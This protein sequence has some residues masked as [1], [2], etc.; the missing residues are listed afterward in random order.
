M[1]KVP[2][3]VTV[4]GPVCL[5]IDFST[6]SFLYSALQRK[7]K[8]F[9]G[10]LTVG[11]FPGSCARSTG[12][13]LW[14]GLAKEGTDGRLMVGGRKEEATSFLPVAE[15]SKSRCFSSVSSRLCSDLCW[16]QFILCGP[17]LR[18]QWQHVSHVPSNLDL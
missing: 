11:C 18:L 4:H 15:F 9:R 1:N 14:L 8:Q 13:S 7:G 6:F 2:S 10:R 12:T 17:S 3:C 16:L 5:H